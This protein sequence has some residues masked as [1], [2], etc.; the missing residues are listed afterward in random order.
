MF[1]ASD[2]IPSVEFPGGGMSFGIG[3]GPIQQ[4]GAGNAM[5]AKGLTHKIRRQP[6]SNLLPV[7][8]PRSPRKFA[9][10]STLF[11]VKNA[12]EESASISDSKTWTAFDKAREK[13]A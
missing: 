5:E 10:S 12:P 3:G 7:L 8:M 13:N 6:T 1:P 11:L 4:G 2:L 9:R